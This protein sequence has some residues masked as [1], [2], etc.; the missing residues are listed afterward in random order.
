VAERLF[1][2]ETEYAFAPLGKAGAPLRVEALLCNLLELVRGRLP[3]LRDAHGRG[4][5]LANGARFYIDCGLHPEMTTPECANPWDVVRYVLAGERILA[6]LAADLMVSDP[7]VSQILVFKCNVDYNGLTTWGCHES[8]LHRADPA[9]LPR[10]IIP[11]LVSRII[12]TGAG[13][14]HIG[15]EHVEFTLSPRVWHL[16]AEVSPNS[17][18]SR[19]VFH[20]KDESLSSEG[21]HR[22]HLLCG[23][24]LCSHAA[25]WLR[26]ATTALVVALGEAGISPGPD[27]LLQ[28]PLEAM[29]AFA[30]DP[31]CKASARTISGRLISALE[32]QRYYLAA[33]EAHMSEPFMPAWAPEACRRWREILDRIGQG[34]HALTTILDWA[35]KRELFAR[36]AL[37]RGTAG[38]PSPD[39]AGVLTLAARAGRRAAV[40]QE[41]FEIDTRFG[42]VGEG[43]GIFAALDR[44]G[45]LHHQIPGVDNIE[46]AMQNPPAIGRAKIRGECIRRLAGCGQRFLCSWLDIRDRVTGKTLDLRDP[47]ASREDW[48]EPHKG[49]NGNLIQDPTSIAAAEGT[50]IDL[51]RHLAAALRLRLRGSSEGRSGAERVPSQQRFDPNSV[52]GGQRQR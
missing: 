47:L 6:R 32:I 2:V 36:H 27:V 39:R 31:E 44:A 12:F 7:E 46:H 10:Q 30:A 38:E 11:H 1:G 49:Q 22:L 43:N 21:Y 48:L 33:A 50:P 45:V 16:Q 15:P 19:G 5:F 41:L 52:E 9:A 23:E 4:L 3:S 40:R 24:S 14:F 17:T 13:G 8:Y 34:P 25:M 37:R 42:Q 35:T 26:T 29:Q 51:S 18:H 20:T 28:S